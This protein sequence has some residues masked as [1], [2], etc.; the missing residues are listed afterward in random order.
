MD[1]DSSEM[2]IIAQEWNQ[3][4]FTKQVPPPKS[5]PIKRA[6]AVSSSS[7]GQNNTEAQS[8]SNKRRKAESRHERQPTLESAQEERDP[9]GINSDPQ[10]RAECKAQV[11]RCV[12]NG[13]T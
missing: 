7:S 5:K 1:D 2:D 8:Q 12:D 9:M 11:D 13:H 6:S 3:A 4:Q 10:K